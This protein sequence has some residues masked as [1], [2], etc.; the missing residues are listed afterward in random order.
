MC[1]MS[2]TKQVKVLKCEDKAV[3]KSGD[4]SASSAFTELFV[5]MLSALKVKMCMRLKNHLHCINTNYFK[6][7]K[8]RFSTL[9]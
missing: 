8:N 3:I 7:V 2:C 5:E 9:F 4:M 6:I 1:C